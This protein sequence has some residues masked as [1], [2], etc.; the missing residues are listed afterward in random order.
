MWTLINSSAPLFDAAAALPLSDVATV[1]ALGA[2]DATG[3]LPLS[4]V[5]FVFRQPAMAA[6]LLLLWCVWLVNKARLLEHEL[7]LMGGI[8][9]VWGTMVFPRAESLFVETRAFL[10]AFWTM[11]GAAAVFFAPVVTDVVNA[12]TPLALNGAK[13]CARVWEGLSWKAR[14][15]VVGATCALVLAVAAWRRARA[16]CAKFRSSK[17]AM[18][19]NKA[20][21]CAKIQSDARKRVP[22]LLFNAAFVPVAMTLWL[23]TASLGKG[24][25]IQVLFIATVLF[26]VLLSAAWFW[27][28]AE[29]GGNGN[30]GGGVSTP[31]SRVSAVQHALAK[32][33]RRRAQRILSFWSAWPLLNC[34]VLGLAAVSDFGFAQIDATSSAASSSTGAIG[35]AAVA[36]AQSALGERVLLIATTHSMFWGGSAVAVRVFNRILTG[37]VGQSTKLVG[38][39]APKAKGAAAAAMSMENVSML[40][41][42]WGLLLSS[43]AVAME[44]KGFALAA[45]ATVVFAVV[46]ASF[47][48]LALLSTAIT[49]AFWWGAAAKSAQTVQQAE[50]TWES[51]EKVAGAMV[52]REFEQQI[53]FWVA[54]MLLEA[55]CRVPLLGGL[56]SLW[57]PVLLPMCLQLGGHLVPPLVTVAVGVLTPAKRKSTPTTPAAAQ[58]SGKKQARKVAGKAHAL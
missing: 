34:A 27:N 47:Q 7:G 58:K 5:R 1:V 56:I 25:L 40:S 54:A 3:H 48:A 44:N 53:G 20:T 43:K 41:R 31:S 14:C 2:L 9:E 33:R 28:G 21:A 50:E 17:A 37:T 38:W 6:L 51:R 55:L 49:L 19:A 32:V 52:D 42:I 36:V 12:A 18:L 22:A 4:P 8:D 24:I 39:L 10:N 35:S 26:P 45:A 11:L 30:G 16:A 23:A 29:S 46:Y 15:S 13:L 57:R